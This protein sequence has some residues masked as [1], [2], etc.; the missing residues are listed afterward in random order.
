MVVYMELPLDNVNIF[1]TVINDIN[2]IQSRYDS[3]I[4]TLTGKLKKA[5]AEAHNYALKCETLSSELEE[6]KNILM[7]ADMKLT[8]IEKENDSLKFDN[9]QLQKDLSSEKQ[10]IVKLRC[11]I[12]TMEQDKK[13]FTRVSHVVA[14]EK[15]NNKL[16]TELSALKATL[17]K[18]TESIVNQTQECYNEKD[19]EEGQNLS[20]YEKKIKG[21]VYYVSCQEDL[22]IYKK[23]EDGTLGESV[24]YLEKDTITQ[25]TKVKWTK[26]MLN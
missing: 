16:R 5:L 25:K 14:M 18:P 6:A 26:T 21:I 19:K 8:N 10:E 9:E 17:S 3:T 1:N 22:T 12:D 20:V 7:I 23:N 13:D 11:T 4:Q 24:G 15:E 2:A